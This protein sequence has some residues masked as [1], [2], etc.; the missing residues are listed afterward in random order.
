M[1]LR[2]LFSRERSVL[3]GRTVTAMAD[4]A[5][6]SCANF[7]VAIIIIKSA[8]KAEYGYY[9]LA[10]PASLFLVTLQNAIVTGPLTVLL[11]NYR[12]RRRKDYI[13]A[14]CWGQLLVIVPLAAIGL[15]TVA[16]LC[17]AG[18]E[19]RR[20][21][22][23]AALCAAATG[24]LL[25][26]YLRAYYY[27]EERPGR[28][29][30]ID[31]LQTAGYV[32]LLLLSLLV[33]PLSSATAILLSGLSAMVVFGLCRRRCM[34]P[35]WSD[36]ALRKGYTEHWQYGKW[37]LLGVVT[38]HIQMYGST[39]LLGAFVDATAV[40]DLSAGRLLLMP[41]LLL[42]MGWGQVSAP[43]GAA[44]LKQNRMPTYVRELIV[45]AV[46][47]VAMIAV[48]TVILYRFDDAIGHF[49]LSN[50]FDRAFDYI[51][52]WAAVA[53]AQFVRL[54]AGMGLLVLKE[55]RFLAIV[56]TL[57]TVVTVAGACLLIPT[58]GGM[59]ALLAMLVGEVLMGGVLWIALIRRVSRRS[60]SPTA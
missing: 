55:F 24:L 40:A 18:L 29:L 3:L 23:I 34:R 38:T 41:F 32:A 30:L 7:L 46:V 1:N 42:R 39:Y 48:Y 35:G 9:A 54:N 25:F 33:Q 13:R 60:D 43:H 44:L 12:G 36:A 52:L 56:S 59:G 17:L 2:A 27:A 50:K 15:L 53:S 19:D 10:F 5:L 49:L 58:Q 45:A 20:Y 4:Q 26:E 57:V 21:A 14:L 37:A 31:A 28:V 6:R 51:P 16:G 8:S 47:G 11:V 22:V